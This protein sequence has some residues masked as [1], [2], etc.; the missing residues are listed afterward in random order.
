MKFNRLQAL[1]KYAYPNH[2]SS[3]FKYTYFFFSIFYVSMIQK[4]KAI[5]PNRLRRK[6]NNSLHKADFG[7]M[8]IFRIL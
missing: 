4:K 6:N 1:L 7:F 8:V 2:I 5:E 3:S